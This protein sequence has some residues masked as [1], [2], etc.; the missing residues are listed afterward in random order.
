MKI[1]LLLIASALLAVSCASDVIYDKSFQ[2]AGQQAFEISVPVSD[3]NYLVTV[4]FGDAHAAGETTIKGESRR[5]Y[6]HNLK[7]VAGEK[8]TV[9]FVVNKRD[10]YIREN[11]A[12]VAQVRIKPRE[13]GKLNWDDNL[14]LEIL[15][16]APAVASVK[17]E[18]A[19][20]DVIS[21]FLCG[22]STVVDQD[23]EP[24]ASWG[25]MV[26]CFFDEGVAVAN[27]AESGERT[28]SFIAA[29]RLHKILSV[30]KPGDYVFI[31]F[32][33]NDQK[34]KGEDKTGHGFFADQ[35]RIFVNDVRS[36][37]GVP[38]LVTPTHRRNFDADGKIV[39]SHLD[40]P[41]GMRAVAAEMDVP[42]IELHDA[43]AVFYEALGPDNSTKAF[44]HY[45]AGSWTGMDKDCADNT[46]FNFYGAYELAKCVV[47][48]VK[49]IELQPLASHIAN[50]VGFNP[51]SPDDFDSFVWPSSPYRNLARQLSEK[52]DKATSTLR[53][54]YLF[55]YFVEQSDGLHLAWSHD[56]LKWT[57]VASGKSLLK[58][59]VGDDKFMRDPSICQGPDGLFHMV[60]TTGWHDRIIA[61][62]SSKDLIHWS[63]Q[64]EI[65]VMA[66]EPTAK[67]CWAPELYYDSTSGSYYIFWATTIPG[68]HSEVAESEKEKG[69]NHRIYFTTT[70][71]F[72]RFSRTSLFFNPDFSVI[73]AAIIRDPVKKDL[74]MF[75]KNEN[76][77]P[78]QKNI[79]LT[80]A[81]NIRQG[82]PVTVSE[83]I[84]GD[85][86][87][88]GP[89]PLFIGKDSLVVYYDRYRDHRYGASLSLDRG[90][91]WMD[92]PDENL[93]FPEGMRHGTA[94]VV[95][96]EIFD[97]L[98]ELK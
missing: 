21:V 33:H 40:Y 23:N 1:N 54:C 59:E 14:T 96:Q 41:D 60:W 17:I 67:N 62:A 91:T 82:F 3:G 92:I 22:D 7:T 13:K 76:A 19:P 30:L 12:P 88:E 95:D 89:A 26:P 8:K 52:D 74:I 24:W 58:P 56:G 42:L 97:K 69:W 51:S 15:G 65:P 75:L 73:D 9:R 53:P 72:E 36:H 78:P 29:G 27:Y 90:E 57:P 20:D 71:D 61:Y 98:I 37:G 47:Q 16:S 31:E 46:H 77:N 10:T 5:L 43:S 80:R 84:H 2:T 93:Q 39:E 70:R 94:F 85:F 83:P 32:G 68:R 48:M 44:V 87:A 38:V 55:S 49:D 18:P 25:Q 4:T 64:K 28:D 86:W 63:A 35:L 50:F 34:L 45:K 66:D 6:V 79:R 11:G 81:G